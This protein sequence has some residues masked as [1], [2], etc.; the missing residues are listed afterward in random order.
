MSV[1]G[2]AGSGSASAIFK[3]Q[4]AGSQAFCFLLFSDD[5]KGHGEIVKEGT[6]LLKPTKVFEAEFYEQISSRLPD[7]VPFIPAYFGRKLVDGSNKHIRLQHVFDYYLIELGSLTVTLHIVLEDLTL[8][9]K[10]PCVLDIKM[11]TCLFPD[12]CPE[13][14]KLQRQ[15]MAA[16]TTTGSIGIRICG[17]DVRF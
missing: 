7:L 17:M 16:K 5:S 2:A 8:P 11:G 1:D 12:W 6:K 9:F 10:K 14:K 15:E 3:L 4:V 13:A